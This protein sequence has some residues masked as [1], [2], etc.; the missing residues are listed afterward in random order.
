[1]M[2]TGAL[3]LVTAALFTGAAVYTFRRRLRY[4][5][6]PTEVA[7]I[8]YHCRRPEHDLD[9]LSECPI[10]AHERDTMD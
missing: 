5:R 3:A 2:L 6:A 8:P 4:T 10:F 7:S 1:M 9:L